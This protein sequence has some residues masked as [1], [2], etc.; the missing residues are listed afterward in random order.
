[1]ILF[2]SDYV[3][4]SLVFQLDIIPSAFHVEAR[5]TF[6]I[7]WQAGMLGSKNLLLI[8]LSYLVVN[9][10]WIRIFSSDIFIEWILKEVLDV[11]MFR[12]VRINWIIENGGVILQEVLLHLFWGLK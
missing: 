7:V 9:D 8:F 1:M 11:E 6:G 5:A 12:L 2:S 10:S 4:I 3:G